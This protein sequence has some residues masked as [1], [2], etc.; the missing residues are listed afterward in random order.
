MTDRVKSLTVYFEKDF[1]EDEIGSLID[2]INRFRGVS[3][4]KQTLMS[5]EDYFAI[6]RARN[7]LRGR[8]WAALY[9]SD[10]K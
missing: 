7:E 5:A 6:D 3:C 9:P 4:V 8:I 2:A 10:D 1:C